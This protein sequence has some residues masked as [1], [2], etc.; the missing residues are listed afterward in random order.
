MISILDY[1][2]GNIGSLINMFKRL[3]VESNVISEPNQVRNSSKLILP[4]VGSFDHAMRRLNSVSGL[5]QALDEVANEQRTPI[6]GICLGMQL[7]LSKSEEGLESGL[8]WIKGTVN[9]FDGSSGLKVPHM[10]WNHGMIKKPNVLLAGISDKS[11]FYFAHS[12]FAKTLDSSNSLM[13]T[14]HG[15]EFDS[16]IN[17]KNVYGVQFHPEKSLSFGMQILHNFSEL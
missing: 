10:G 13:S 14:F 16:V 5:R 11:R 2:M 1:G 12:Y 8:D 4:G 3:G 7:L 9:K 6:L 15:V 17:T